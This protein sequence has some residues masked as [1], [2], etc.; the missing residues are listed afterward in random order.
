M[1]LW[2]LQGTAAKSLALGGTTVMVIALMEVRWQMRK[3]EGSGQDAMRQG[4][5]STEHIP[6]SRGDALPS[7]QEALQVSCPARSAFRGLLPCSNSPLLL[8][9][10]LPPKAN[11]RNWYPWLAAERKKWDGGFNIFRT[12][13]PDGRIRPV[14]SGRGKRVQ[15]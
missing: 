8:P 1:T 7:L 10:L 5:L 15:A 4:M 13:M 3:E 2:I 14:D 6:L 11:K 12:K 9:A